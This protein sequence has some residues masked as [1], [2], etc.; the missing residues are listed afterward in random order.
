MASHVIVGAANVAQHVPEPEIVSVLGGGGFL[1]SAI[2]DRLLNEGHRVRIFERP[3]IQPYRA[4]AEGEGVEWIEGDFGHLP[5]MRLALEGATAVIHLVCT[6]RPKSSNDEPIFD[7][8]SNVIATLQLLEEMRQLGI[9]K[10]LFSS[11]G[12]TVYGP[13]IRTPIDEDHPTNPTTSYGITKLT[14]EKYLQLEK[15]L[16]GLQPVILRV[17]NPYG[18]RQRVEYAQ[19]VVA[20]FLKRALAGEPIEI[21]GDGSVIRDY[22]HVEDV[23]DAFATA[24]HYKGDATVFNIGSGSGTSL[25]ELV[26]ILSKQLGQE[27]EVTYKPARDFDVKSNVLCCKRAQKELPWQANISMAAGLERTLAWLRDQKQA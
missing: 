3:R 26:Q 10:M 27:L 17:A 4:F 15:Q 7:V 20:A 6:T 5:D 18:E 12:G 19:G 11:S 1:G 2:A 22:L 24:L 25:N 9:K 21:W 13:P 23:A 16:H 14:I 8:Q